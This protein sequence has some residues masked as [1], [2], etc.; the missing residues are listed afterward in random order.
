MAR[1]TTPKNTS[2]TTVQPANSVT[3]T[4]TTVDTVNQPQTHM[5]D[6]KPVE[7]DASPA[8]ENLD[9]LNV[10]TQPTVI[11]N[12]LNPSVIDTVQDQSKAPEPSPEP[13]VK[14]VDDTKPASAAPLANDT[15]AALAS[16]ELK[17]TITNGHNV[18]SFF[19][20]QTKNSIAAQQADTLNVTHQQLQR[21]RSNIKQ[22]NTLEGKVWL[23]IEGDDT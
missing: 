21:I 18:R 19:E 23:T 1:N 20:S 4:S 10:G 2:A 13:D 3:T 8:N 6:V 12:G 17:I 11:D 9:L 5:L 7:N 15:Q 22:L 14:P 16:N